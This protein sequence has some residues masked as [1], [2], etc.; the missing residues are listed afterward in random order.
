MLSFNTL[1]H[2]ERNHFQTVLLLGQ[3][4]L[5]G[6]FFTLIFDQYW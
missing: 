1:I 6:T 4:T 2:L 5:V 3:C